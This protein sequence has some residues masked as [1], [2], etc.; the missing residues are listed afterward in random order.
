MSRSDP[1]AASRQ[2]STRITFVVDSSDYGGAEAYVIH[3]L[4][5]LPPRFVPT[6]VVTP[7]LPRRISTI[8]AALGVPLVTVD[9][10]RHKLDLL[11]TARQT[12]TVLAT[13]PNLVHVN[14]TTAANSRHVLGALAVTR[15]PTVATLHIVAPIGSGIQRRIL[16]AVYRRLARAIAVSEE[17]RRQLHDDLGVDERVIRVVPNGVELRAPSTLPRDGGEGVLVGALGR[18]TRQ[19]GFDLLIEAVRR[20]AADGK[21]V[22]AVIGGD[23]IDRLALSRQAAGAPVELRGLIEDV[24]AF[25]AELDVFCL[26]S[27]WEGL[28]FALLEAMMGGLPCVAS[29]VGDVASALGEAGI[30]V[31]PGD[32]DALVQALK[33]LIASPDARRLLGAAAHARATQRF[34]VEGMVESTTRVY[35]EALA[36]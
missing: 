18:L 34:S 9:S 5:H 6:V 19:K 29:D 36:P 20:L 32:I 13:R 22:R 2:R 26:P 8:A 4:R 23:G 27:R 15:T 31:P 17:T 12:R 21:D 7:S 11:R 16:R 10:P 3:L 33:H 30:V 25:L 24:S 1:P 14:L 28:P 35:D